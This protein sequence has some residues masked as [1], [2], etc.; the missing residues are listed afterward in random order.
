MNKGILNTILLVALPLVV[1]LAK[2]SPE[3]KTE[4]FAGN[5]T[6]VIE[7]Y[8]WGP[9]VSKVVL[10]M[11]ETIAETKASNFLVQV[12]RR[13]E[14]AVL[15]TADAKGERQVVYAYISDAKGNRVVE[16]NHVTLVLYVSPEDSLG[17]PIQ[18]IRVKNRGSNQW[19]DYKMTITQTPSKK[20]WDVESGRIVPSIDKFDLTGSYSQNGVSLTYGSFTP[21]S[22][23]QSPLIIWLHG[24]GEG[25]TDPSIALIANKA[26]NYAS[27]KIQ[28]IFGGAY[29]LVPQTPTFWM[30]S[31]SGAYTRGDTND[32]YN[33]ALMGLIKKYVADNPNIDQNRIYIGG[34]SNGGY[35]SL[36][37]I[38]LNPDYFAAAFISALAYQEKYITDEQIQSV[39][40]VPIWFVHSKDDQTTVPTETV[41][42]LYHRLMTANAENIHFSFYDH[43]TDLSGLYGGNEYRFNGH[44]S[45]IYSHAN[46]ADFD[47]DGKPVQLD[48]KRVTIMEW[49]AEQQN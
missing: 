30:E 27:D 20:V 46:H 15:N 42:P 29:V 32:I 18:Y 1:L 14:G 17:S 11:D 12:E 21:K 47:Y 3:P 31:D 35:M 24:G 13:A 36:K 2:E 44:W 34:C 8:D 26:A 40:N 16:G 25:G 49:M 7:G 22:N 45:W 6:V 4:V 38:L 19:I 41:V 9:A 33:E 28:A 23:N 39:K 10:S 43:V 37:L 5:Y 48:G